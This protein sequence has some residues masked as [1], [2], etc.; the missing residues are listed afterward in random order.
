MNFI[1]GAINPTFGEHERIE[2]F[3]KDILD[4]VDVEPRE[5]Q[6]PII[7]CVG[8]ERDVVAIPRYIRDRRS[9]AC[10]F[11]HTGERATS[12]TV[13]GSGLQWDAVLAQNI[14]RY[15]R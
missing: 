2:I 1:A 6:L 7:A 3:R 4:P 10:Q 14:N 11:L 13:A 5:I 15:A 12:I 8:N 9:F